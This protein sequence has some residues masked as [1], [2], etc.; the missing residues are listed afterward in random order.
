MLLD[1]TVV[2]IPMPMVWKLQLQ[3]RDMYVCVCDAGNL[4][5]A[6]DSRSSTCLVS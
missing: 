4:S 6:L 1:L 3:I 2:T 5:P